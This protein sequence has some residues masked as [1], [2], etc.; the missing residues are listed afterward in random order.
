MCNPGNSKPWHIDNP[1]IF[2]TMV[3]LKPDTYSES[4]QRF[5]MD[6]FAKIV[7]GYNYFLYL[8]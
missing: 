3:Y 1:G 8:L 2:K 6:C 5:K 4:S 7:K